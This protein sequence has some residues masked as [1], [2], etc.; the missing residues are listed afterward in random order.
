MISLRDMPRN[1]HVRDVLY[2]VADVLG[3]DVCWLYQRRFHFQLAHDGWTLAVSPDSAGR[4]RFE[5]CHWTRP[6]ATLWI[7]QDDDAR[8][9]R[10]VE[11]LAAIGGARVG[12]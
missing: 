10:I 4:I 5:A 11:E 12:V 2:R 6:V 3:W 9:A 8:L 7:F 1:D